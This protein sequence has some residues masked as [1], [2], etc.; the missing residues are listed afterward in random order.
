MV[1]ARGN[2]TSR[3]CDAEAYS[4]FVVDVL[5]DDSAEVEQ[6]MVLEEAP[7]GRPCIENSS[8]WFVKLQKVRAL[9]SFILWDRPC[10]IFFCH[11]S[12]V[13]YFLFVS[14]V[15]LFCHISYLSVQ[16]R[17]GFFPSRGHSCQSIFISPAFC[18]WLSL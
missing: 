7:A 3:M 6:S 14:R 2:S 16:I 8:D 17:A 5:N 18:L 9:N 13:F 1:V 15:V 10:F 12:A 11:V 4:D